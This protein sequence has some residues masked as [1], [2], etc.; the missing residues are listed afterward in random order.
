MSQNIRK[1][2]IEHNNGKSKYTSG[3]LPWKL[4]YSEEMGTSANARKRE[5]Y[6]KSAAAKKFL[7]NILGSG[8]LPDAV[9]QG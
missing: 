2:L 1:R 6:L 5:R 3:H 8:S 9:R 7:H 4:I